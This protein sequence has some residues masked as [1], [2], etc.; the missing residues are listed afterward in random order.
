[1]GSWKMTQQIFR[2]LGFQERF[3]VPYKE[4]LFEGKPVFTSIESTIRI[5]LMEV[6][7]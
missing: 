1:M 7:L 6:N 3:T 2:K 5:M 4:F